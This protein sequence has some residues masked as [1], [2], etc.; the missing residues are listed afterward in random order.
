MYRF[1]KNLIQPL[2]S[3]FKTSRTLFRNFGAGH[4][5]GPHVPEFYEKLGKVCLITAYLW[6]FYKLKEDNG[7]IFGYYK[8]W[9][10]EHEH[11]HYHYKSSVDKGT[12]LVEDD[13]EDEH[14][15]D[16]DEEHEE[17]DE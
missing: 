3:N 14:D 8:P 15:E 13:D 2:K 4:H 16:H 9:L 11:E 7:Q 1:N 10:H 12:T 5:H 6:I 17:D